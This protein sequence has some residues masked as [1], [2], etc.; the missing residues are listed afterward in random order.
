MLQP[1]G[2]HHPSPF[3]VG[4]LGCSLPATRLFTLLQ[5]PT[6]HAEHGLREHLRAGTGLFAA[7]QPSSLP[8]LQRTVL[9]IAPTPQV[10]EHCK[11]R[12][13]RLL[14]SSP[15]GPR[16][17]VASSGQGRSPVAQQEGPRGLSSSSSRASVLA[18]AA[19]SWVGSGAAPGS[20]RL[21][22]P[23]AFLLRGL[24]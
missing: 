12:G 17:P 8:V 14:L 23:L 6:R 20:L 11:T 5:F 16:C 18:T 10:A 21:G 7:A 24:S 22:V 15:A 9:Q 3:P 1:Q 2:R 4:F 19:R 13:R